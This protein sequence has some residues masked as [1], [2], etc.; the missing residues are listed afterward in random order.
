MAVGIVRTPKEVSTLER[1]ASIVIAST[2]MSRF[3]IYHYSS[4]IDPLFMQ[5]QYNFL[6]SCLLDPA[7]FVV[8]PSVNDNFI[9]FRDCPVLTC[10]AST[11]MWP[12]AAVNSE[13]PWELWSSSSSLSSVST[14]SSSSHG[15]ELCSDSQFSIYS[16]ILFW[17]KLSRATP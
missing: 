6:P 5:S 7:A 2:G 15:Q 14:N 4:R 8:R 16:C 10:A 3:R 17:T 13:P 9:Y 11:C 12:S 1:L